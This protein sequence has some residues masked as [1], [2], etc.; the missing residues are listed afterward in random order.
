MMLAGN[1]DANAQNTVKWTDRPLKWSDFQQVDQPGDTS[2][3][4]FL[5]LEY[6]DKVV[7]K[8]I[9]TYQY[10]DVHANFNKQYSWVRKGCMTDDEL[11]RNQ[12]FFNYA[13]L[14]ARDIRAKLLGSAMNRENLEKEAIAAVDAERPQIMQTEDLSTYAVGKDDFDIAEVGFKYGGVSAFF[15]AGPAVVVP[16][17]SLG[18]LTNPVIAGTL[19][20]GVKFGSVSLML[21]EY[22]GAGFAKGNYMGIGGKHDPSRSVPYLAVSL[23]AGYTFIDKDRFSLA[24]AAGAGYSRYGFNKFT[25]SGVTISEG[26]CADFH[27]HRNLYYTLD[28]PCGFDQSIRVKLFADQMLSAENKLIPSINLSASFDI[29]VGRIR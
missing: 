2:S 5:G 4:S 17:G 11:A 16:L 13:E 3:L 6:T 25:T 7:R 1:V 28:R 14:Q 20:E 23:K 8:G 19:E 26:L 10:T 24:A 18:R 22:L 15:S 12:A 27:I 9:T 21:E 29:L